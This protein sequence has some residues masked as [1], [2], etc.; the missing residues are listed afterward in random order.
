MNHLRYVRY[1]KATQLKIT[2]AVIIARIAQRILAE[3]RAQILKS[4]S[5][6]V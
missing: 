6:G 2:K 3:R 1:E 5:G 4:A